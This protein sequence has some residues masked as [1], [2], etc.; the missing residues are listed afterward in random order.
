MV[1]GY[2]TKIQ[3][4][5]KRNLYKVSEWERRWKQDS[6]LQDR[7]KTEQVYE[8]RVNHTGTHQIFIINMI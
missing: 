7:A 3:K 2:D 5:K 1:E 6:W 4:R 8:W